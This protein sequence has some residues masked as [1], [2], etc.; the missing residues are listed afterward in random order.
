MKT[1]LLEKT[2]PH[3]FSSVPAKFYSIFYIHTVIDKD[4]NNLCLFSNN[5]MAAEYIVDSTKFSVKHPISVLHSTTMS[6]NVS[7]LLT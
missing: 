5:A 1:S 4:L 2:S 3:I 7:I 6:Q